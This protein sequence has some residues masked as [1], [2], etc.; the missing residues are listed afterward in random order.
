MAQYAFRAKDFQGSTLAGTLEAPTE[1][2]AESVLRERGLVVVALAPEGGAVGRAR[3]ERM[4]E[5]ERILFTLH[6]GTVLSSGVPIIAGLRDFVDPM[7]RPGLRRVVEGLI[8][9]LQAGA[10]LSEALA[11]RPQA[12]PDLY[13]NVVRA[14]ETSGRLDEVLRDLVAFLEWQEELRSQIRSASIY[15][16]LLV[17][18]LTGLTVFLAT[19]VF[20]RFA[21]VLAVVHA[22]LPLPTRMVLGAGALLQAYWPYLVLAAVGLVLLY[23]LIAATPGGRLL[24][25][26]LKLRIPVL[27]SLLLKIAMSRFAHHLESLYRS[28]VDFVVALNAV[29]R[30]MGNTVLARA[31]AQARQRV[32]AGVSLTDALRSTGQFPPL[33]LRMAASGEASGTLGD[34]LRKVSQY[35]DREVPTAVRRLFTA[36]EPAVIL[37]L[38]VV[39]LGSA[40]A[41]YLPIYSL[42]SAVRPRGR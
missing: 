35:Y 6:L 41:L 15:P 12:F 36:L 23:R 10:S 34:T 8:A 21:A 32:M 7:T 4:S 31:V 33:V 13:V 28:G 26:G 42:I 5:H 14:G 38:A 24:I 16:T 19:F 17:I 30:V 9:D 27:G 37:L 40:L 1:E 11:R 2:Q 25:D 20:P 3:R 29:E 39:V 18:A 22:P